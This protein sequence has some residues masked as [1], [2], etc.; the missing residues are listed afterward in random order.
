[1][2]IG[3]IHDRAE[4]SLFDLQAVAVQMVMLRL[5]ALMGW[6][7]L[8]ALMSDNNQH[9]FISNNVEASATSWDWILVK[10]SH[11][12]KPIPPPPPPFSSPALLNLICLRL[13]L[14]RN[15]SAWKGLWVSLDSPWQHCELETP[16]LT[17]GR[18][19]PSQSQIHCTTR[20]RRNASQ[21]MVPHFSKSHWSSWFFQVPFSETQKNLALC[22]LRCQGLGVLWDS[23]P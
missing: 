3:G 15:S 2:N 7:V 5:D 19:C 12:A 16:H 6:F 13:G 11:R 4:R 23:A 14:C 22:F 18:L 1:M 17:E 9:P 10:A 21:N 8:P 20:H